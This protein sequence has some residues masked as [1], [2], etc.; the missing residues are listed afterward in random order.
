MDLS[1]KSTCSGAE[2]GSDI[3]GKR[4]CSESG[5]YQG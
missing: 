4:V 3:E 5:H 1:A 2:V